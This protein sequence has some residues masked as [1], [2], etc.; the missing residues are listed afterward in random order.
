[1]YTGHTYD[2]N[3]KF[4]NF[5]KG[6]TTRKDNLRFTH[7][8]FDKETKQCTCPFLLSTICPVCLEM[9]H[10]SNKCP[11]YT[12]LEELQ[13]DAMQIGYSDESVAR[14][15]KF[16]YEAEV[17]RRIMVDAYLKMDKHCTFCANG[18]YRDGFYKTHTLNRCPRLAC[19]TCT[20][21]GAIGH[22]K[23][24]CLVKGHEE[25]WKA[26]DPL[27][28]DYILDFAAEEERE[29]QTSGNLAH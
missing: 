2:P 6:D 24:K 21:C 14:K 19:S 9:G 5:C 7:W 28:T 15:A 13:M 29:L 26:A 17:E 1:M 3:F 12:K 8:L 23:S 18:N 16:L 20:Y 10:T 11:N 4:C 22:T 25:L 27:I